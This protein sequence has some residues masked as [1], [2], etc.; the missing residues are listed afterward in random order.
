MSIY[1]NWVVM[2]T[3]KICLGWPFW[4]FHP[5][6]WDEKNSLKMVWNGL[7]I[8]WKNDIRIVWLCKF[9]DGINSWDLKILYRDLKNWK[10]WLNK[11][12]NGMVWRIRKVE[13]NN[14]KNRMELNGWNVY[15]KQGVNISLFVFFWNLFSTKE[16]KSFVSAKE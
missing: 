15:A 8:I 1:L 12:W 14:K 11:K 2:S 5:I 13:K 7:K 10:K 4:P 9:H 6:F 3:V 16:Q